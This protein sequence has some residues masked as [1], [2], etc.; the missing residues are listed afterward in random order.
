MGWGCLQHRRA[1][2]GLGL[3]KKREY[4]EVVGL[5]AIQEG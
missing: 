3:I 2:N 5:V 1:E 4:R